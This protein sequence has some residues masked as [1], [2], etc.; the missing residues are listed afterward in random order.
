MHLRTLPVTSHMPGTVITGVWRIL[1]RM[2]NTYP[3]HLWYERGPTADYLP[4][5]YALAKL[6]FLTLREVNYSEATCSDLRY[7][8]LK[9]ARAR[10]HF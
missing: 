5:T 10:V 1:T 9:Y 4:C 6:V 2:Y 8:R 7:W 3:W